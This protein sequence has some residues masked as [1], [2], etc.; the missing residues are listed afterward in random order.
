MKPSGC[1]HNYTILVWWMILYLMVPE[2]STD[3][4][5]RPIVTLE[6]LQT[7]QFLEGERLYS[8]TL[9][10]FPNLLLSLASLVFRSV[11]SMCACILSFFSHVR[12]FATL[13]TVA[14]Q[15]PLSTKFSRQEYRSGLHCPPPRVFSIQGLNLCLLHLLNWQL[16]SWPLIPPG[17]PVWEETSE[18]MKRLR[19]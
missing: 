8:L 14:H 7:T 12:L 9:L 1:Q 17:S 10:D 13:W 5:E 6:L 3:M 2:G 19:K 11:G 18:E 15:F 16:I 4:A